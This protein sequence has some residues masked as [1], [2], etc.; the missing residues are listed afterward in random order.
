[1]LIWLV[2]FFFLD[3]FWH[4]CNKLNHKFS[5]SIRKW[6]KR[7]QRTQK[8]TT[9]WELDSSLP[10]HHKNFWELEKSK[11]KNLKNAYMWRKLQVYLWKE[12][13]KKNPK[14]E[15]CV[16]RTSSIA[17]ERTPKLRM[18]AMGRRKR[19]DILGLHYDTFFQSIDIT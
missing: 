3:W 15:T 18:I 14:N 5:Y 4:T 12:L 10:L 7:S 1:M 19:K 8:G 9:Y 17:M 13:P 6:S 16:E 11:S 2:F